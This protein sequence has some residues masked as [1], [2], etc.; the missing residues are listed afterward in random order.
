MA[1]CAKPAVVA[2]PSGARP[3]SRA[4]YARREP[5]K[6]VLHQ[7]VRAHLEA[8][9][10]WTRDNYNKPLPLRPEQLGDGDA[11]ALDVTGQPM[12]GGPG[13]DPQPPEADAR[14]P[15]GDYDAVDAPA[16]ED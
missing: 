13:L 14:S 11:I 2:Y 15:P 3:G 9:L 12:P 16:P 1:L 4:T 6:T 8:F 10:R 5:E 7:G